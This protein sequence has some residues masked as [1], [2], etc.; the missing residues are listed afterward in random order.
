MSL[1]IR[2]FEDMLRQDRQ[3]VEDSFRC[4]V[5]PRQSEPYGVLIQLRHAERLIINN[6]QVTLWRIHGLVQK[7]SKREDHVV[8]VKW[9]AVREPYTFAKFKREG[10]AVCGCRPGLCKSG[11]GLL[12][13]AIDGNQVRHQAADDLARNGV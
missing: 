10:T 8:C 13:R 2:L 1:A 12:S 5:G 6:Q 3:S 4:S 9:M 7:D 11:L